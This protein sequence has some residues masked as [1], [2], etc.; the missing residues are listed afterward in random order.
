MNLF[1]MRAKQRLTDFVLLQSWLNLSVIRIL[2]LRGIIYQNQFKTL[3]IGSQNSKL[4]EKL[5]TENEDETSG[6]F[7]RLTLSGDGENNGIERSKRR[8]QRITLIMALCPSGRCQKKKS[9]ENG[10][11]KMKPREFMRRLNNYGCHC[12]TKEC[13]INILTNI[14]I[15]HILLFVALRHFSQNPFHSQTFVG[16]KMQ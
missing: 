4:V 11:P 14:R 6:L 9:I 10:G 16:M 1:A 15:L 2:R 3:F 12:W 13:F 7:R 8:N 5:S